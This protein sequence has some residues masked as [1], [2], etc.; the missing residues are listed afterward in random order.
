[1]KYLI[2]LEVILLF[3]INDYPS[4]NEVNYIKVTV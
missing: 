1:M 2:L 3:Y 4:Y